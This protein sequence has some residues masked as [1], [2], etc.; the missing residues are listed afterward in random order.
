VLLTRL[1]FLESDF[2]SCLH[3]LAELVV[4]PGLHGVIG[5]DGEGLVHLRV[6]AHIDEG[7]IAAWVT[8]ARCCAPLLINRKLSHDF[9]Q[10]FKNRPPKTRVP[11]EKREIKYSPMSLGGGIAR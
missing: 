5:E 11:S 3:R 6:E 8:Y 1:R 7:R 10:V 2:H 9:P 4:L